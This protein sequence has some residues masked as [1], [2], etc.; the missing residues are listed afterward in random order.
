MTT[1]KDAQSQGVH[2][3]EGCRALGHWLRIARR[4]GAIAAAALLALVACVVG[5]GAENGFETPESAIRFFVECVRSEDYDCALRA[6]AIEQMANGYDHEAM[7][8]WIRAMVPTSRFLPSEYG[9]FALRNRHAM[10]YFI[11]QQLSWMALSIALPDEY[12]GFLEMRTIVDT[13]IN[14]DRVVDDMDPERLQRLEI[15]EIGSSHLLA[16]ERHTE[17]L[18]RQAEVHGADAATSRAVLYKIDS[19]YFVGGLQLFQY[20]G[21]WLIS[22]LNDA[23]IDQPAIGALIRVGDPTRFDAMLDP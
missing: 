21:S 5:I 14:F 13:A 18:A 3:T 2:G 19:E 7:I 4:R 20:N 17:H 6:C 11:L 10:E 23:L 15:I 8:T 22:A 9:L 16:N 12:E 1:G